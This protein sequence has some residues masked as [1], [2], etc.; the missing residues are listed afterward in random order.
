MASSSAE[1]VD[2]LSNDE[3]MKIKLALMQMKLLDKISFSFM[4]KLIPVAFI[5]LTGFFAGMYYGAIPKS[6]CIPIGIGIIA[7]ILLIGIPPM[8]SAMDMMNAQRKEIIKLWDN[9]HSGKRK[10]YEFV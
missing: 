10:N 6:I 7:I 8:I 5:L 3:R 1:Q 9:I 4:N 2:K